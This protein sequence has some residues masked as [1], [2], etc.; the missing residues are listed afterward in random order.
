MKKI[1]LGLSVT[2]ASF[3]VVHA[4][5][6]KYRVDTTIVLHE[7]GLIATEYLPPCREE[8]TR[9][10]G[11]FLLV[12][13]DDGTWAG[14]NL[15]DEGEILTV[16]EID[17]GKRFSGWHLHESLQVSQDGKIL[18]WIVWDMTILRGREISG[19]AGNQNQN[20]ELTCHNRLTGRS[21]F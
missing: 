12:K 13:N 21:R 11:R 8:G 15:D 3:G 1:L 4:D 5:P 6:I 10:H 19:E 2:A 17:I 9:L 20:G 14:D 7:V 16:H 18:G